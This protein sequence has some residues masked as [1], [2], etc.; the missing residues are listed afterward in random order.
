M[1][2]HIPSEPPLSDLSEH[3]TDTVLRIFEDTRLLER[4]FTVAGL[5]N[6]ALQSTRQPQPPTQTN[7]EKSKK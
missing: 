6:Q 1:K 7:C 2:T 4:I 5:L 3:E